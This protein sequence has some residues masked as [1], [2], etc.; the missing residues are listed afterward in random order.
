MKGENE[1]EPLLRKYY[2]IILELMI[3]RAGNVHIGFH[4]QKSGSEP[5]IHID[6]ATPVLFT[7]HSKVFFMVWY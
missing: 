4:P 1:Y 2:R 6:S 7:A 5:T 3:R